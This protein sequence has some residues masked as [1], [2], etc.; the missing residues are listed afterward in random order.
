[1]VLLAFGCEAGVGKDTAVNYL[2][3]Q[4]GGTQVS[5]A[6]P[7]YDTH[8][9]VHKRL[10]FDLQKDRKLLQLI[11]DWGREKNPDLFVDL[12]LQKVDNRGGNFYVSDV[13][14]PNEFHTLK[15]RGFTMVR[16]I[17]SDR[18]LLSADVA[19]HSSEN[20]IHKFPWDVIL[21]ND[22]SFRDLHAQLDR[23][24]SDSLL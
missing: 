20:S 14:Y 11:G 21:H 8:D 1:M 17:R 2:V 24:Y 9:Y 19:S 18:S 10:G 6:S 12:L 16:L 3:E 4:K 15:S 5:F 7:L 13:R 22:G 23:V